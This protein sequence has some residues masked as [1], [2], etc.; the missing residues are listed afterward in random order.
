MTE[1]DLIVRRASALAPWHFDFEL[2]DGHRTGEL[3]DKNDPNGKISGLDPSSIKGFFKKYY[4]NGLHGKDVL[5]VG[6]NS[7]GYCF[8]AS[9][10][11]ANKVVGFDVRKHWID[12]A[13]FIREVR[14]PGLTNIHFLLSDAQTS[15]ETFGKAD[16]VIFKGVFYHL[17]DPIH[18]LL[19]LCEAAREVI[20]VNTESD[21][22]IPERC[23]SP[24]VESTTRM[25]S[26]VHGLCWWP[27][28]PAALRPVLE[29]AGFKEIAVP[30]WNRNVAAGRGRFTIIGKR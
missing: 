23:L 25:M 4:P 22:T 18:V 30:A 26:G 27:G 19:K 8:V 17:P 16:I 21:E 28:G 5:D 15:I 2:G 9:E 1:L 14:Y 24:R 7:G 12:Q 6:C 3:N 11:G 13:E 10:L 29:F 20:F